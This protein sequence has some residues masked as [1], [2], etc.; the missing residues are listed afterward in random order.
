MPDAVSTLPG[1]AFADTMEAMAR[2]VSG[3]RDWVPEGDGKW[4]LPIAFLPDA[5]GWVELMRLKPGVRLR[6]HRHTGEVH[7]LNL[8][9]TR[10]LN[11]GRLV[12]AGD[13]IHEPEGNVDWWEAVGDED[14][15]VYVVV[16]GEV[17]YLGPHHTVLSHVTTA[18][19]REDYARHCAALGV[20]P[21]LN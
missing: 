10:R 3:L 17:Q 4:A 5:S 11:D 19:R 20:A 1:A 13:Y 7:A 14:L 21:V 8:K 2:R 9:G 18:S 16:K 6:L 12:H 15:V